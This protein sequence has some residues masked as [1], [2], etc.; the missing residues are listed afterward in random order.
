M[1]PK[2][3][4]TYY[5]V[6]FT[7]FKKN[8]IQQLLSKI[9]TFECS[10]WDLDCYRHVYKKIVSYVLFYDSNIPNTTYAGL[11][12]RK[13]TSTNLYWTE[14]SLRL[15]YH[16]ICHRVVVTVQ[17]WITS[18]SPQ[19]FIWTTRPTHCR[20]AHAL[21]KTALHFTSMSGPFVRFRTC[22]VFSSDNQ[23]LNIKLLLGRLIPTRSHALSFM[24]LHY[25]QSSGST[26]EPIQL[27]ASEHLSS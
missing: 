5:I 20:I 17:I 4:Q 9:W 25:P 11:F 26:Q 19:A 1:I 16:G 6:C 7:T 12:S 14:I 23:P 13:I 10:S 22:C 2:Y 21:Q 24:G 18:N 8:Y 3:L 15:P 27:S